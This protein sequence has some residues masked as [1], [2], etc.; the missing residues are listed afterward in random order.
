MI[1]RTSD[2]LTSAPD[3][4]AI[5]A[6]AMAD[7]TWLGDSL[8]SWQA[9]ADALA[10]TAAKTVTVGN[11]PTAAALSHPWT[12]SRGVTTNGTELYAKG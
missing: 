5:L 1:T 7:S 8:T 12:R 9:A 11:E 3:H 2:Y 6:G 10:T 4:Q